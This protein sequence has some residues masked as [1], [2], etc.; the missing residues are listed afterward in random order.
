MILI[1]MIEIVDQKDLV[2]RK[3]S[4]GKKFFYHPDHLGSTAIITNES[5]SITEETA[6]EPFGS[7][8]I[9]GNDVIIPE[10]SICEKCHP[11]LII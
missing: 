10:L 2:A 5:G 7:L 4:N 8:F 9:G 11:F 3:E 6:Y 1:V